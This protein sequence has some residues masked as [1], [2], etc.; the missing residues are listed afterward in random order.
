[1]RGTLVLWY[2]AAIVYQT[3]LL[4]AASRVGHGCSHFRL[5]PDSG[6]QRYIHLHPARAGRFFTRVRCGDSCQNSPRGKGILQFRISSSCSPARS[7][8]RDDGDEDGEM[9]GCVGMH[10]CWHW[11]RRGPSATT[12]REKATRWSVAAKPV[13]SSAVGLSGGAVRG[14]ILVRVRLTRDDP[15]TPVLDTGSRGS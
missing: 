3:R 11:H 4:S 13:S 15:G 1:M 2:A 6:Q 8:A 7:C 5:W 10:M 12:P 9:W 14:G